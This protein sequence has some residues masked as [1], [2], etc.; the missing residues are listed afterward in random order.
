MKGRTIQEISQDINKPGFLAG[1]SFGLFIAPILMDRT[2]KVISESQA[3]KITPGVQ[4]AREFREKYVFVEHPQINPII[5]PGSNR[6]YYRKSEV[7]DLQTR[8]QYRFNYQSYK[9]E[10]KERDRSK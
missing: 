1:L 5:P 7:L 3:A 8:N 9:T 4:N 10:R 2:D 6:R